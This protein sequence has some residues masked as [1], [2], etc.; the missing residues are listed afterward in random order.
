MNW[1][2]ILDLLR[3]EMATGIVT[4]SLARLVVAAILGGIIGL[5]RELRHRPAGLRTNMFICFGS[6]MFTILS[7]TLAVEHLGD[8]TRI[9]AQIIPGIGFIG[10][11]SILHTRGLTSGLTTAA[12][13]FVVAGVGMAAGGGLYMTATFATGAILIAL[14][15]LGYLEKNFNLKTLLMSYEVKGTS[16]DEIS[17]EV[18]RVLEAEHRMMQNV[19]S[20][21]TGQYVRLQFDVSGCHREQNDLLRRLKAS[22]VLGGVI[23]LGPREL[24]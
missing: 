7:D 24:E 14:F 1:Q 10:A 2:N 18:N 20:G 19:I 6:A 16:V 23:S 4:N 9:A 13:L 12:T 5:E 3:R 22:T 8:H 21:S 15:S 11:G 17:Q